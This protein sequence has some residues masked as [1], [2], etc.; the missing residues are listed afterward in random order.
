MGLFRFV[1]SGIVVAGKKGGFGCECQVEFCR[2][3]CSF[4]RS[5]VFRL[6]AVEHFFAQD[7]DILGEAEAQF[8][9]LSGDGNNSNFDVFFNDDGFAGFSGQV[10][11]VSWPA[12]CIVTIKQRVGLVSPVKT[13]PL[14]VTGLL[15]PDKDKMPEK[16][17]RVRKKGWEL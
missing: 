3:E 5:A 8:Y 6:D 17:C 13:D 7:T 11:H 10:Q 1:R 14:L 12:S 4:C 2:V 9:R 15:T 16:A